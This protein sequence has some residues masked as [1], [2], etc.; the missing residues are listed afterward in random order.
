MGI[1]NSRKYASVRRYRERNKLFAEYK[2]GDLVELITDVAT[3][4]KIKVRAVSRNDE[5]KFCYRDKRI[6]WYK[7]QVSGSGTFYTT[8]S[9][10]KIG[11]YL[12]RYDGAAVVLLDEGLYHVPIRNI[13]KVTGEQNG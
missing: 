6:N 8:F 1:T 12:G 13:K 9:V 11:L 2:E 5:G 3:G 4:S 7:M 10:G